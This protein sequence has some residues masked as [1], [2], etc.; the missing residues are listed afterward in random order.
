MPLCAPPGGLTTVCTAS[1]AAARVT[2]GQRGSR[3][4]FDGVQAQEVSGRA[5]GWRA[6][7]TVVWFHR[8]L[9]HQRRTL[10]RPSDGYLSRHALRRRRRDKG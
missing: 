10:E 7:R 1:S 2:G 9:P 4:G 8:V 3:A 6:N 5:E